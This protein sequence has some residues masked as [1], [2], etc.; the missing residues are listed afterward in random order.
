MRDWLDVT[1]WWT[2]Y[3]VVDP[4]SHHVAYVGIT[5]GE[6]DERLRQHRAS[7]SSAIYGF[8]RDLDERGLEPTLCI[9]GSVRSE[10]AARHLET[11]LIVV[12][13]QT[14]NKTHWNEGIG[15]WKPFSTKVF[16]ARVGETG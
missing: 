16:Q 5:R 7:R 12:M 1:G 3:G 6:P 11:A 8:L 4:V 10:A 13:P 15:F 9:L 2:V 14:Y